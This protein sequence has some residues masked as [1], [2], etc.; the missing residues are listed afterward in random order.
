MSYGYSDDM[1]RSNRYQG[2]CCDCGAH[3]PAR[4]GRLVYLGRDTRRRYSVVC[5][6]CQGARARRDACMRDDMTTYYG[7]A[8]RADAWA[9]SGW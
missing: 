8:E 3:V 6:G 9:P 7:S 4:A 1:P 2:T 5:S